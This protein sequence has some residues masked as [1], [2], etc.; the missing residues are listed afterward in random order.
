MAPIPRTRR[1]GV[2]ADRVREHLLTSLHLGRLAPGDRVT[3]VRRLADL[4]GLNRKTIHRAYR[5][6]AREGLLL[7]RPGSGTFIAARSVPAER[8]AGA[9]DLLGVVERCR[10]DAASHGMSPREFASFVD[11]CLGDGLHGQPVAV[12]ECNLEQIGLIADDLRRELGVAPR[13]LTLATIMSRPGT[14]L[15]ASAVITT[16]CHYAEVAAAAAPTGVPV[17]RVAL[18]GEFPGRVM[19]RL[20]RAP[21][22]LVVRDLSF[23]RPFRRL[24]AQLGAPPEALARLFVATPAQTRVRLAEAGSGAAVCVSPLVAGETEGRI[25][26]SV[27]RLSARWTVP[28]DALER[29]RAEIA[30]SLDSTEVAS[31][32]SRRGA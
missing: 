6:L 16:D 8:T 2:G 19:R 31:L 21:L 4:T 12:V 9:G 11:R 18:D 3:S 32:R 7:S 29:L 22:V 27:P 13:G 10:R 1:V 15:G 28:P 14:V 26:E 25:P 17:F 5:E 20:G 30:R 24:L 23:E